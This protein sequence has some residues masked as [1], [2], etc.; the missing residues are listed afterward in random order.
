MIF[1]FSMYFL[2]FL[3]LWVSILIIDVVNCTREEEN[4]GT[5]KLSIALI[6]LGILVFSFIAWRWLT[7][8][9]SQNREKYIL[10]YAKEERFITAEFLMTYVIPLFAFDFTRWDGMVLF[11]WFFIVFGV[12]VHRHKYFCTNLALE[13]CGYRVFDCRLAISGQTISKH[14]VSRN[15]L[16]GYIGKTI[17][18]QKYNDDY[19]FEVNV[20]QC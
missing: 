11:L 15:E 17:R 5:E 8:K 10:E 14:I 7:R 9:S 4:L 3:P 2:S 20:E 16:V 19:H 6:L 12:L 1:E 18:T 13:F